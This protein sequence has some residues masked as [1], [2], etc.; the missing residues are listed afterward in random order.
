LSL[1][2]VIKGPEGVVLAADSRVTLE[3]QQESGPKF[4]INYDNATKLLGFAPPHTNIGVVTYGAAVIVQRTAHSF[5]P[6]FE[7]ALKEQLGEA[8]EEPL[9]V[10]DFAKHLSDFFVERWAETVTGDEYTGPDMTFIVGGYDPGAAYGKVYLF[11]TPKAP[12]PL[13]RNPGDTDFGMT[14]GGQ[15]QIASRIV[16]GFDPAAINIIREELGVEPE[17]AE[18]LRTIL[19]AKLGF[20]IPYAVL[21]LQDCVDLAAFLISST[22]TA[23]S[24]AI[25]LRGVGG[26]IDVATVTRTEG[27][28]YI[29]RK[30]IRVK[31]N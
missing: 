1:A 22:V 12:T 31:N 27:L 20:P 16:H 13:P 10:F 17:R 15:L 4:S 29:Q 6:E 18:E 9:P 21:P 3:A 7:V 11:G 5:I 30:Q 25:G 26:P 28:H 24:L 14:W 2:V 19:N 23:Q 8:S